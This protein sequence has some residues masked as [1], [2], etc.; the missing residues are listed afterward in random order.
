MDVLVLG[1]FYT[2]DKGPSCPM[3]DV[4]QV[5]AASARTSAGEA[6]LTEGATAPP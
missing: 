5:R 3:R 6:A 4:G 1:D 2:T